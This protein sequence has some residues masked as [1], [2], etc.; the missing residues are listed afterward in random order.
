MILFSYQLMIK[1]KYP[2][3]YKLNESG[4]FR[5]KTF[6]LVGL[7]VINHVSKSYHTN[8]ESTLK[9][10]YATYTLYFVED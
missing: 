1:D 3:P 4:C 8:I 10:T 6:T 7:V 9:K 5:N 2:V